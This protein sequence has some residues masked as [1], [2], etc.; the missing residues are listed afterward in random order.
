MNYNLFTLSSFAFLFTSTLSAATLIYDGYDYGGSDVDL[1]TTSLTTNA[2]GLTGHYTN[3]GNSAGQDASQNVFIYD[4]S[5]NLSLGSNFLTSQGGSI[6][7]SAHSSANSSHSLTASIDIAGTSYSGDLYSSFLIRV[8]NLLSDAILANRILDAGRTESRLQGAVEDTHLA[9]A[10]DSTRVTSA[11]SVSEG[12]TYL[13]L[14]HFTNVGLSG[15]GTATTYLFDQTAYD[16]WFNAN[17]DYADLDTYALFSVTET[18][19]TMA[20]LADGNMVDFTNFSPNDSGFNVTSDVYFDE[21]RWGTNLGDVV[22]VNVPEP[23]AFALLIG[24]FSLLIV[25]RR[26]RV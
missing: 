5:V 9:T 25:C 26:R 11:G 23:S 16:S 20:T 14:S 13:V 18:S 22:S 24:M 1:L 19:A 15:G 2:V 4:A 17:G 21:L 3:G 8:D 12:E 7:T 10:Y 6:Y